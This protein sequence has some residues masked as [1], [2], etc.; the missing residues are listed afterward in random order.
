MRIALKGFNLLICIVLFGVVAISSQVFAKSPATPSDDSVKQ[1]YIITMQDP[2]LSRYD[3]RIIYTPE[4]EYQST[5]LEATANSA[6]GARKLNVKSPQS[7]QYLRFL[8]ERFE[9]FRGEA[10][11]RLGRQLTTTHRYRIALNGFAADLN[12]AEAAILRDMPGV[13]SVRPDEKQRLH[14]DAGPE[15]LGA[16]KI[17]DGS[18]GFPAS[19]GEGVVVGIIDSGINWSHPA[20]QDPGE[21]GTGW[22][23][24]NPYG[25]QLGLCSE[26]EV[27][28][29]DKLAGVYDFVEDDPAS[30]AVEENTNGKDNSGHGSHVASI[31]V[32]NPDDVTLNGI[33]ASISGVAPNANLITYRVC[34]IAGEGGCQTS[35]ILKA[36]D[37]AIED[38][39]DVVNYSIG[40]D[41][42]NPWSPGTTIYAFLSAR[43]AGIY[44][45][46]SAGNAGPNSGTM[47]SPANAPWITAVGN[48]THDRV[49]ASLLENL[50]GGDTPPPTSLV[51]ASFTDGIGIRD[52]VHAREYG[53]PL[54]GDGAAQ[55]QPD[56][57]SNTGESN[58]FEPG[59]FNGEIVVCDR[60]T[61]GRVEKGKNL[62]LAGAGGYVL[63]NADDSGELSGT[64]ADDHCLPATHINYDD[65]EKLRTWLE[66]GS[67]HQASISG[68]SVFH[69]EEAGDVISRLSS[70]GPNQ[71][72]V[73]NILKPDL[74]A[75]G[76]EILGASSVGNNF[77]FLSGTSMASP[78]VTGGAALIKSVHPEWTPPM[79][80]SAMAMTATPELAV[81]YDGS[82]AIPHKRGSGR[83][84]LD[85]AVNA[86]LYLNETE[87][88]FI[89]ANPNVG[90][91]PKNLNL[92]SLVDTECFNTCSF[93]RTVTDLVGG[94]SWS[95]TA[96]GFANGISVSVSPQNFSLANGA[97]QPLTITID[98]SQSNLVGQWVYGEVHL[99]SSGLPD[100]VLPVAVFA[101][102]GSLPDDWEINSASNS[103]WQ[104]F[105]LSDMVNMPDAT[106]TSGGLVVPTITSEVLPQDPNDKPYD[107][108]QGK[109]VVLHS[110]PAGTLWLH[111]ETLMSTVQG[112]DLDLYVGLDANK[113]GR[114]QESEELCSSTSPTEIEFC[115]LFTPVEG[116]YWI[117]V[118]N[119]V[120]PDQ[121]DSTEQAEVVLKSAVVGKDTTSLLSAT[122]TGIIPMGANHTV[123]LSWDNVNDLPGTELMGAVGIG[124]NREAPNNIGIIPVMFNKTGIASPETLLLLN[125]VGRGLTLEG[126]GI[127][128]HTFIDIPPGTEALSVSAS[129]ADAGQ[130]ESLIIEL[131]QVDFDNAFEDAP[132]VNFPPTDGGP[133]ASASGANG[134]GPVL[135]VSGQILTPGRWFVVLKNTNAN[136]A[137]VTVQADI[138]STGDPLDV[139]FG[140]WEPSSRSNTH[141]GIDFNSTGDYRALLWYTYEEDG[142]PTWYQAAAVATGSN[143]VVAP[144]VRYTNDGMKQQA[145]PVGH[146]SITA[147][148]ET[149]LIFSWVLFGESGSDRMFVLSS[150]NCPTIDDS[151]K[152]YDG[153]WSAPAGRGGASG[154]VNTG[155]QAFVHYIYDDKGNPV[156]LTAA[157]EVQSPTATEMRI[158]QWD[159]YCPNCSGEEPTFETMGM[160]TREFADEYNLTW[161][162]DYDLVPPLSGTISRTDVTEKL[163]VHQVC[164]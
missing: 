106:F 19:G 139:Q 131:Y 26:D 36:I 125:G 20:F 16:D 160:F 137:A 35:A 123:R 31:A 154:L 24:V 136:P 116:D 33:P 126:N 132:F 111:A 83:P 138:T 59:T 57:A 65:G 64:V 146:V 143:I 66:T 99:A 3:G 145:T 153:L 105:E 80:V 96:E 70:R 130:S 161:T 40:G 134:S 157:P 1:R 76:I 104:E 147:I 112:L 50:T 128:D 8:D 37:Q 84:Q 155:A 21:V 58:P 87:N 39:V 159:G 127:H 82:T 152:S 97:D 158:L 118:Q 42:F 17:F 15:W 32:G 92:P 38:G 162:L 148:G 22:D 29:N 68:F 6:T 45:A 100:A 47:G 12:S 122:G 150:P 48:A 149:D 73:E 144:L 135:N 28:C 163:T 27:L 23:H 13:V 164:N 141:Q 25:E 107:G 133:L 113:D 140:L 101:D 11:L 62:Q 88:E 41:A 7:K 102:G 52:I 121:Y 60:G 71:S 30:D 43:A 93:Q 74:I 55:S 75:P 98:L 109:M 81:D 114:P 120:N 89:R 67:N 2:P 51:G 18:S 5:Q 46:T 110:V 10:A 119:W 124:T 115:D 108:L 72:P 91:N 95:A 56:C 34:Y 4:R 117:I 53:Y 63:A 78:H 156:W 85:Q 9:S 79:L 94:A 77:A 61:Y 49:F 14:T 54:C 142:K 129:G 90:G 86:G 151:K 44:V 69:I 103:G